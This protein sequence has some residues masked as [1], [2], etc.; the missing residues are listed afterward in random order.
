MTMAE[1]NDLPLV[2]ELRPPPDVE[3]ALISLSVLPHSLLL[4]SALREPRLGRYSFLTADPFEFVQVLAD[5]PQGLS[6]LEARL[7]TWQQSVRPDLPPFQGGAA[8]LLSYDLGRSLERIPP[9]RRDE[10]Q[11]PKLAIGLYDTVLAIDHADH[12]AWLISQGFPE[13]EPSRRISRAKQRVEQFQAWLK[14]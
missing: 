5:E 13:T 3:S 10:F 8:G 7:R 2:V 1:T 9:P 11:I 12:R 14:A 6:L 4:D